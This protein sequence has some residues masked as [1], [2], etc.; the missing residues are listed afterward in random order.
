MF[1]FGMKK[2]EIMDSSLPFIHALFDT[3]VDRN[4]ERLG[5]PKPDSEEANQVESYDS[6]EKYPIKN[7]PKLHK[8]RDRSAKVTKLTD[9]NR[10]N[11]SAGP[12]QD[13][14]AFFGNIATIEDKT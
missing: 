13:I 10:M 7:A 14:I 6:T 5:V 4:C 2:Q 8:N 11:F 9:K 1:H 3:F 12:K